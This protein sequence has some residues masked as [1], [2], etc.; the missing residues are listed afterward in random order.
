MKKLQILIIED[1]HDTA[2]F[3]MQLLGLLGYETEAVLSAK[4][5]LARLAGF[6]P[7]VIFLDL[8]L[9][10][11][12]DGEDILYQ[13]RSNPRFD[14]TRVIVITA[15][16]MMTRMISDLADL[17]LIKPID[18][19]QLK[20]M[21]DRITSPLYDTK[22]LSFRD[23]VTNLFNREF[24]Y[25][26]L[27]HAYQ[28]AYRR[29]D[30]LYGVVAFSLSSEAQISLDAERVTWNLLL[31]EISM[32]LLQH[33]RPTD[34]LTRLSGWKY[35]VLLEELNDKDDIHPIIQRLEAI[36]K[37]PFEIDGE[38]Y[39]FEVNFGEAVYDRNLQ[40]PR[41]LLDLAVRAL[42]QAMSKSQ[43]SA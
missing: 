22:Q 25:V 2:N 13:V 33:L 3:Y 8:N 14:R 24:L 29:T 20:V 21:V 31:R 38:R 5:A 32:R 35:A 17:I 11:E 26:R 27:E 1:D 23:P 10:S 15:Y 7:H 43:A 34:T 4:A 9:G 19:D 16:P 12:I 40:K 36:L 42:E 6:V 28:R 39:L 37:A 30:F 41:E 18:F